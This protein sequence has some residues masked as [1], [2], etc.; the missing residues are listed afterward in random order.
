[1]CSCTVK[2]ACVL[3]SLRVEHQ[4]GRTI[5]VCAIPACIRACALKNQDEMR[6]VV[7]MPG[8]LK[9]RRITAFKQAES[10]QFT[11]SYYMR[12]R[13]PAR[14][15]RLHSVSSSGPARLGS[16]GCPFAGL[17]HTLRYGLSHR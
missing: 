13:G 6:I 1:M 11:G 15:S 5:H 14:E 4:M 7:R 12:I 17:T 2:K 3:L 9:A 16:T 10:C 8:H